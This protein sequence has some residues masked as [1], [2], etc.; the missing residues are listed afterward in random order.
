MSVVISNN[1]NKLLS[2]WPS[3]QIYSTTLLHKKG[4]SDQQIQKYLRAHLIERVGIGV[5]KKVNDQVD[6]KAGVAVLQQQLSLPVHV[7]GLTAL[8]LQGKSQYIQLGELTLLLLGPK[9]E[10]LPTW[11]KKYSSGAK[12]QYQQTSLFNGPVDS[13][14]RQDFG[15]TLL[16]YDRLTIVASAPER[17]FMEYLDRLPLKGSYQEAYELMENLT[18][19]R[20]KIVQILLE[21][22]SSLK[23]KRL[24]LHFAERVN[25]PWFAKIQTEKIKLGTGNRVVFKG[26]KLDPKYKITIPVDS[27]EDK[28]F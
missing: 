13:F 15:Y 3:G 22:C 27:Y 11:F 25:H 14:G 26:G 17:A 20:S 28:S 8:A 6:W 4:Y 23:V 24:F 5:Y 7:G 2:E 9:R 16:D 18:S 19:L 1:I 12:V 10:L 21:S